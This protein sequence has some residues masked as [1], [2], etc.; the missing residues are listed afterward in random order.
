VSSVVASLPVESFTTRD[1]V[2]VLSVVS[3]SLPAAWNAAKLW[4]PSRRRAA[5][6]IVPAS[7]ATGTC[8]A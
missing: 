7:S 4:R 8:H 1:D 5:A 6:S 2:I 3:T